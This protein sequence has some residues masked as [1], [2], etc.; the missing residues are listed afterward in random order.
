MLRFSLALVLLFLLSPVIVTSQGLKSFKLQNGFTVYIW[1]DPSQSDIFGSVVVRAGAYNDPEA[2]TGLAHYLEHLMFKGTD[3]IG[4]LDWEKEK[5]IYEAIIAKYDERAATSDA[6]KRR[7]L[8]I[9]INQLTAQQSALSKQGEFIQLVES[10]GGKNLNAGTSYDWTNYHNSFPKTQLEKWLDLYSVRLMNPVFRTFQTELETVYEEYNMYQDDRGNQLRSFVFENAFSNSPYG[11]SIIGLGDHLKNPQISK[12]IEFYNSWY[13]PEN[14]ALI[15]VGDIKTEEVAGLINRKFGRLPA[16]NAPQSK[17]SRASAF[18]GRKQVAARIGQFPS[19]ALLYNGVPT[20][21][22]DGIALDIATSML[23]NT[24]RTGLLDKLVLDGDIMMA[25]ASP[26]SFVNDGRIIIQAVPSYD[27][28]QGRYESHRMVERLLSDQITKLSKGEV[29]EWL[30]ESVKNNI[31]R[32]YLR[33]LESPRQKAYM[34]QEA[35][36]AGYGMDYVLD[37][38]SKVQAVSMDDVNRVVR[39]Y[40]NNDFLALHISEGKP[41]KPELIEKPDLPEIPEVYNEATSLYARWFNQIPVVP[42]QFPERSFNDVRITNVNEKSKL[43]YYPNNENNV[44]TMT[45]KYGIGTRE[46][47]LLQMATPLMN[48]AGVLGAFEPREFR[49]ALSNLNASVNYSVNSNYLTVS[50][51]GTEEQLQ[52]ICN[53]I[54]RQILMPRLDEKQL[55]SVK[56][57]LLQARRREKEEVD[58]QEEA[59]LEYML[60]GDKSAYINRLTDNEVI[61][62]GITDLTRVFQQATDYAAEIHYAGSLSFEVVEEILNANL[63]L[64]ANELDSNSPQERTRVTYP[65]NRVLLLSNSDVSQSRIH[66]FVEGEKFEPQKSAS[67]R[68][69]NNYFG[70]GFGSLIFDEIREKNS[71]AY[72]AFGVYVEPL[73]YG[74]SYFFRGYIG[75]QADKTVDAISLYVGILNDMPENRERLESL[76]SFIREA[77]LSDEPNFRQVS[78]V[79]ESLKL[80]GFSKPVEHYVI[81]VVDSMIFDDIVKFYEENLKGRPVVIGIVGNPRQIDVRALE[82]FGSVE[83]INVNRLFKN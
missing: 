55:N 67:I 70:S 24:N 37:Y 5:P 1:E 41:S 39:H 53:L 38:V 9:E 2:F 66:F 68:M 63:P 13:V 19:L 61:R 10:I 57:G 73:R 22:E 51:E 83:R 35:F 21:H 44:F 80:Q 54:T 7:E 40:F 33:S 82:Q 71:M 60:Y 6:A 15:L 11:R 18:K 52:L 49:A 65:N 16:G 50:V 28:S 72:S 29:E 20:G 75:T 77:L 32:N 79:Y 31:I 64:K 69:F 26:L 78:Q 56:G 12:L 34:V 27:Y 58:S 62:A 48:T 3:R 36:V 59:L 42:A 43:F 76:R 17:V 25:V 81:P 23:S 30:L 14:M 46:L 4:A 8:D 45:I 74:D 47:P